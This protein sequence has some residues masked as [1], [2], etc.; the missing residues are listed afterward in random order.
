[1]N[2]M[3]TSQVLVVTMSF[4]GLFHTHADGAIDVVDNGS[5]SL[6]T[7]LTKTRKNSQKEGTKTVTSETLLRRANT[8][9][10]KKKVPTSVQLLVNNN[11]GIHIHVP[12]HHKKSEK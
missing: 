8:I 6:D 3:Y 4:W 11:V 5:F 10:I 1:M 2:E 7:S 9:K 12:A